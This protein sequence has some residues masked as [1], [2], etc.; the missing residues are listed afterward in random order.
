MHAVAPD[1]TPAPVDDSSPVQSPVVAPY[2]DLVDFGTNVC[3]PTNPCDYCEGDCNKD[4]DCAGDLECYH[5]AKKEAVP[6]CTGGE[7]IDNRKCHACLLL[8]SLFHVS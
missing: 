4:S 7:A 1:P 2:P 3:S 5:R 6:S 8:F